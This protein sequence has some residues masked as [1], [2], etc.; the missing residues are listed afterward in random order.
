MQPL[1]LKCL[2]ESQWLTFLQRLTSSLDD[3]IRS[4]MITKDWTA[5]WL[6]SVIALEM[7]TPIGQVVLQVS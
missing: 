2:V 1:F 5:P 6:T 7:S 4:A 3:L